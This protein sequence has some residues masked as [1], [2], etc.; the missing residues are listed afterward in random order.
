[1]DKLARNV[2]LSLLIT[3]LFGTLA[4][5]N[6]SAAPRPERPQQAQVRSTQDTRA[7]QG[8][9]SYGG[10]RPPA[11]DRQIVTDE[12]NSALRSQARKPYSAHGMAYELESLEAV[13]GAAVVIVGRDAYAGIRNA[14]EG[15]LPAEVPAVIVDKIRKMDRSI[16][17][18]YVTAEPEAVD[19]L[20]SYAE[21]LEQGQ[22]LQR[23]QDRFRQLVE[24]HPW[25]T[26]T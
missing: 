23:F 5:C 21:A 16:S 17:Q 8:M 11:E 20:S 1:M 15:N 10:S 9:E 25:M 14:F 24:T 18:V 6:Q 22:P 13:K 12:R 4:G 7:E 2:T 26:A 19:F 3:T